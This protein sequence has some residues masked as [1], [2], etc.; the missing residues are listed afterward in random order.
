MRGDLVNLGQGIG[1]GR[2][3]PDISLLI[4]AMLML[5]LMLML[6]VSCSRSRGAGKSVNRLYG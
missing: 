2:V 4:D 3:Q 1:N 5:M 6:I